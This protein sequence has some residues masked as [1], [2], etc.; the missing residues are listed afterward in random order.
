MLTRKDSSR[1]V[2]VAS[3]GAI[4]VAFLSTN[5]RADEPGPKAQPAA[6][7]R[8]W[9]ECFTLEGEEVPRLGTISPDGK[10]MA[11]GGAG[12][13]V[14]IW[15]LDAPKMMAEWKDAGSHTAYSPDG[16]LVACNACFS[17]R[18]GDSLVRIFEVATGKRIAAV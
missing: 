10:L 17:A 3:L 11:M 8:T 16:K 9:Q 7:A 4:L 6:G 18:A 12:L 14:R 15:D 5:G 13:M 2:F 1:V